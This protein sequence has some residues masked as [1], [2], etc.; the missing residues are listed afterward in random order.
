MG[1]DQMRSCEDVMVQM[2][3]GQ[4]G[5]YLA[6]PDNLPTLVRQYDGD[7]EDLGLAPVPDGRGTLLGGEGYM[8]NA[9]A[10]DEQI[11]AALTWLQWRF[12]NPDAVE[13]RI[14]EAAADELP[15]GLPTPPTPDIW[16]E[17]EIRESVEA[18]KE[19]HA[20]VPV[21]NVRPFME[22]APTVEGRIEPPR[23]QEVYAILDNVMQGVLTDEGADIR[24]LLDRAEDD[25]NRVYGS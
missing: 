15:V 1:S 21:E 6:A 13:R 12:V 23:A 5:M 25:V 22:G 10:S 14:E 17:G 7:Y 16:V 9:G 24:G 18:L 11:E 8:I 2:G 4:L 20:N 3:A 19:R